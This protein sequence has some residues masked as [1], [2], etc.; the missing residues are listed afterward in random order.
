MNGTS[1]AVG[2]VVGGR[3]EVAENLVP[4]DGHMYRAKD[5]VCGEYVAL[6]HLSAER[7]AEGPVLGM[8]EREGILARVLTHENIVS[9][10]ATFQE[11]GDRFIVY[12][13][14]DASDLR[15]WIEHAKTLGRPIGLADSV[16]I[17]IQI[18]QALDY[19][20]NLTPK[21]EKRPLRI[22]HGDLSPDNILVSATGEV[23]L[24]DFGLAEPKGLPGARGIKRVLRGFRMETAYGNPPYMSPEQTELKPLDNRSDLFTLGVVLYETIT[25]EPL[26]AGSEEELV[27]SCRR[28]RIS[29]EKLD[30]LPEGARP[31]LKRALQRNPR[32]RFQSAGEMLRQLELLKG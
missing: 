10:L 7:A 4:P 17:A 24:A 26:Y 23:K 16:K 14:E 3:Y 12:K 8:F 28:A 5:M 21:E 19:A 18:C 6:K 11:G 31:L 27:E 15:C 2:C 32:R 29:T 20:Y 1:L 13:Y 30:V 22:V 25:G 9:W